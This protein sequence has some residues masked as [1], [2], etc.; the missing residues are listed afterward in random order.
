MGRKS[1]SGGVKPLG[2]RIEIDL[3]YMG[4]RIRPTL[5]LKPNAANLKHARRLRDDLLTEIANGSFDLKTHFPDYRFVAKLLGET[6]VGAL[7]QPELPSFERAAN[8]WLQSKDLEYSTLLGYRKTLNYYWLPAFGKRPIEQ[9]TFEDIVGRI[10][11][12]VNPEDDEDREPIAKKTR[13][14]ILIA[15]RGPFKAAMAARWITHDPTAIIE[16]SRLQRDPPDPFSIEEVELI[17]VKLR[18]H[19]GDEVADYYEFAFFAG[20]RTS[21]QIA[22]LWTDVD[23]R[24]MTVLVH[25]VRAERRDKDRTKTNRRRSVEL[26]TR[27]A[28]VIARQRERTQL[29]GKHVFVDPTTGAGWHDNQA[30]WKPWFAVM[31]LTGVRYRPP[32]ECRDTSVTLAL[33]A[34]AEPTWV[35][36]QHGHSIAVMQR[37]YLRWIPHGDKGRNRRLVDASLA[38]APESDLSVDC[39]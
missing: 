14:N 21:E 2:D 36:T 10:N 9:I 6:T 20:L 11:H 18:E 26:N 39:Q 13:N 12:F 25:H 1:E 3:T 8:L 28:A 7:T 33:L 31:K 23:L 15:L 37:D 16:N 27:A 38:Q 22:L 19:R 35:A 4:R 24:T 32:K 30:P 5:A 17:L 34:G 29:A